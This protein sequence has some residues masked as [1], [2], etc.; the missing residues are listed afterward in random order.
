[1]R[2]FLPLLIACLFTLT[3]VGAAADVAVVR[4][5]SI[6]EVSSQTRALAVTSDAIALAGDSITILSRENPDQASAVTLVTSNARLFTD[7]FAFENR[8]FAVGI[9]ESQSTLANSPSTSTSSSTSSTINPDSITVL[10]NVNSA[11]GLTRLL[12]FEFDSAGQVINESVYDSDLPLIPLTLKVLGS[13]VAIVG[14]TVSERGVQGF[15]A[16]TDLELNFLSFNRFGTDSTVIRSLASLRTLYG[17]SSERLAGTDRKSVQDGVILYL[18]SSGEPSRVVRSF[19]S[20]SQRS[21]DQ[22]SNAHLAV[23]EVKRGKIEEVAIT[24]FSP[25]G[26]PQWNTR[27][28]G[29]DGHLDLRTLGLVTSKKLE[30]ISRIAPKGKSAVFIEY[31]SKGLSKRGTISRVASIP[32]RE[33]IDMANGYAVI[34]DRDSRFQLVPLAP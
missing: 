14:S 32:A 12:L 9:G 13:T 26:S 18:D 7:L 19:L 16:T 33:I 27:F 4:L 29:S 8:F 1:M 21:W 30:G 25:Q 10:S 24:K 17:S 23:G 6:A 2:K 28:P 5:A 11:Q 34:V 31:A 3:S 15:L 20:S 22:V